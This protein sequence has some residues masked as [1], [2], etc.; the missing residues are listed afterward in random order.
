MILE[1][2]NTNESWVPLVNGDLPDNSLSLKTRKWIDEFVKHLGE[3]ELF[4]GMIIHYK[5]QF[6]SDLQ[7][8][9]ISIENEGTADVENITDPMQNLELH[10]DIKIK[11][12]LEIPAHPQSVYKEQE[13]QLLHRFRL[14][15]DF[16][17]L[18]I[19]QNHTFNLRGRRRC[20]KDFLV[21]SI[22][23][24]LQKPV[25]YF[26]VH[27]E[28]AHLH[29]YSKSTATPTSSPLLRLVDLVQLTGPCILLIS[30]M[31]VF[32]ADIKWNDFD[33]TSILESLF[34]QLK[35]LEGFK[36][37]VIVCTSETSKLPNHFVDFEQVELSLLDFSGR[38]NV[39]KEY[40]LNDDLKKQLA[41]A[42]VG[43]NAGDLD[44]LV[45]RVKFENRNVD[46]NS[47]L[48]TIEDFKPFIRVNKAVDEFQT[49]K[50]DIKWRDLGGYAE[51]KQKLSQ[52]VTWP[53]EN[54]DVYKR[55]GIRPPS[56]VLLYGPSG[57]GKTLLVHAMANHSA[58]NFI[59]IKASQIY[60]KYLGD[61]EYQIRKIF[62][63]AKNSSPCILFID[64][65]DAVASRREW[66]EDGTGGVNERVLSTLLNE[67]DGISGLNGVL[68]VGCTNRPHQLDDALTRPGR[69]DFH[70][71]VTLPTLQDRIDIIELLS[72]KCKSNLVADQIHNLAEITENYTPSDLQVLFREGGM[73]AMSENENADLISYENIQTALANILSANNP[74]GN[75]LPG[76][77]VD[78]RPFEHFGG[79]NKK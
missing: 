3:M 44:L 72:V 19:K 52:L 43:Y 41:N 15:F 1:L 49:E 17:D 27:Q 20:G 24:K 68:V 63:T 64:D 78:L 30:G 25:I 35:R 12:S 6:N 71:F 13:A 70:Y 39:L 66:S 56:G 2:A 21:K 79:K 7:L 10:P 28:T 59:S 76:M 60:S 8:K 77:A 46:F 48:A 23:F 67:M 4:A 38:L 42:T 69:L 65:L 11:L 5:N 58:M 16:G 73:I 61:S 36:V 34:T 26:N 32:D 33:T 14:F 29:H 47:S 45:E 57:C 55:F 37:I 74:S 9:L 50:K 18:G 22:S 54:P 31:E 40:D 51:I 75:W 62:Q 53:I